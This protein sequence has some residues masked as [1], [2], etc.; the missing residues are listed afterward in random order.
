MKFFHNEYHDPEYCI[1]ALDYSIIYTLE[2]E[3]IIKIL[4]QYPNDL[5]KFC[6]IRDQS[7]HETDSFEIFSC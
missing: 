2:L 5:E 4:N 3:E 6:E 7:K 1:K